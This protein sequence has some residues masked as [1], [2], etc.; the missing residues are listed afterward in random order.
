MRKPSEFRASKYSLSSFEEPGICKKN[1]FHSVVTKEIERTPSTEQQTKGIYF[2]TL[3]LGMNSGGDELP[4]MS[5]MKLKDGSD[6]AELKRIHQQVEN[7]KAMMDSNSD[8]YLGLTVVDAQKTMITD[9]DKIIIDAECID[10]FDRPVL[11]D[12]KFTGDVESDFGKFSWGRDVGKMNWDQ[13]VLYSEVFETITGKKPRMMMWVFDASPRMG[14][15]AFEIMVSE[16]AVD[17]IDFRIESMMASVKKYAENGAPVT[18]NKENCEK[19]P[20]ECDMRYSGREIK[21]NRVFV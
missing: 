17:E 11:L 19:C 6:N 18:P 4:D 1:W 9:R 2:E 7:Y 5:F 13:P 8:L 16:K 15:K 20:L 14:I 10:E 12:L 21:V 3:C